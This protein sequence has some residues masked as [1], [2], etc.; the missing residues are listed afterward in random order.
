MHDAARR[1]THHDNMAKADWVK[2]PMDRSRQKEAF[3][4]FV[5]KG[6]TCEDVHVCSMTERRRRVVDTTETSPHPFGKKAE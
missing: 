4:P 5:S 3:A 1:R 2:H 6:L